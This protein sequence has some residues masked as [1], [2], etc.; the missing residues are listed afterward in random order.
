MPPRQAVQA[1]PRPCYYPRTSGH[2][3]AACT[4][5]SAGGSHA[6]H[7]RDGHGSSAIAPSHQAHAYV[8]DDPI[9]DDEEEAL[10]HAGHT[11]AVLPICTP[12]RSLD[13]VSELIPFMGDL[14][15]M[16]EPAMAPNPCGGWTPPLS[17]DYHHRV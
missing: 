7:R 16:L 6:V 3:K 4:H 10:E 9:V 14:P 17:V 2:T 1:Q 15:V 12:C 5:T 8:G 11:I 13:F